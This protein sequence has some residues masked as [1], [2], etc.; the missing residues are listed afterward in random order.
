MNRCIEWKEYNEDQESL[1]DV[2]KLL[3]PYSPFAEGEAA[4]VSLSTAIG[5]VN[6]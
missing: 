6:K 1:R 3:P 5:L 4:K 2:D